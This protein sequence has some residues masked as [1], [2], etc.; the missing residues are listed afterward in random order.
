[1]SIK[2]KIKKKKKIVTGNR[3]VASGA[4]RT[5][6][7]V[8][9]DLTVG[10]TLVNEERSALEQHVAIL[11]VGMVGQT[12]NNNLIIVLAKDPYSYAHPR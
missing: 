9:M 10:H 12:E 8:V 6:L 7:G 2:E 11:Q 4:E 1:M 3:L 5:S